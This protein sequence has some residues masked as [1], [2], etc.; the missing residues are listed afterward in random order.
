MEVK[1][2]C[3]KEALDEV[4]L[5]FKKVDPELRCP[6]NNRISVFCTNPNCQRSLRC[7]DNHCQY[8]SNHSH[9]NCVSVLLDNLT[10]L[11]NLRAD[12][13]R[14]LMSKIITVEEEF[15]ENLR[16]NRKELTEEL[17]VVNLTES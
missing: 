10:K 15:I 8:C 11:I 1:K 14:E 6:S 5:T 9:P 13:G 7:L 17:L 16:R 4:F 2:H 12:R 3:S